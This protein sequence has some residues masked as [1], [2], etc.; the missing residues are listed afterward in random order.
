MIRDVSFN[1]I[2]SARIRSFD[3][4]LQL[5]ATPIIIKKESES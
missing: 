1:Q 3:Q 2:R 5:L 4:I